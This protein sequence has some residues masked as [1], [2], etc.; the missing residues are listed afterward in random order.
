[1]NTFKRYKPDKSGRTLSQTFARD[2]SCLYRKITS[3]RHVGHW[4][5]YCGYIREKMDLFVQWMFVVDQKLCGDRFISSAYFPSW[6]IREKTSPK[7][8]LEL[9]WLKA[10]EY[11]SSRTATYVLVCVIALSSHLSLHITSSVGAHGKCVIMYYC[12]CLLVFLHLSHSH[13][14][15]V[16]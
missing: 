1:M 16:H 3:H 4:V 12:C 5:R 14:F 10:G 8:T 7:S 2:K 13:C 11:G 6:I 9:G 15:F